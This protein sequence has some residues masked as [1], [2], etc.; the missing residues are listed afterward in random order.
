MIYA[1]TL[2]Q[3]GPWKWHA[4]LL[5]T[6]EAKRSTIRDQ[7]GKDGGDEFKNRPAYTSKGEMTIL[8][9]CS[10]LDYI[11]EILEWNWFR[12]E[13]SSTPVAE[14][15]QIKHKTFSCPTGIDN[16]IAVLASMWSELGPFIVSVLGLA[17]IWGQMIAFSNI[18]SIAK[19]RNGDSQKLNSESTILKMDR[20]NSIETTDH[21]TSEKE[22]RA[23]RSAKK[24]RL[25]WS[26]L[27]S[28]EETVTIRI[29]RKPRLQYN[30]MYFNYFPIFIL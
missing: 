28:K 2:S 29:A 21:F 6:F 23:W 11:L 5:N 9:R 16:H 27:K 17:E 10:R 25:C 20:F 19:P 22:I 14:L 26:T 18:L 8:C 13:C 4:L 7:S 12:C 15:S 3:D 1:V 30:L 24:W